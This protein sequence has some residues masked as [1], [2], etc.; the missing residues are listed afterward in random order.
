MTSLKKSVERKRLSVPKKHN[1][2]GHPEV[3][4][5]PHGMEPNDSFPVSILLGTGYKSS[6]MHGRGLSAFKMAANSESV[7][8]SIGKNTPDRQ[9]ETVGPTMVRKEAN[10]SNAQPDEAA[11][12]IRALMSNRAK[13]HQTTKLDS[14]CAIFLRGSDK[15]NRVS[16]RRQKATPNDDSKNPS[17]QRRPV[18]QRRN[19]T[20]TTIPSS[21]MAIENPNVNNAKQ[22]PAPKHHHPVIQAENS[23]VKT[24]KYTT[25]FSS[26]LSIENARFPTQVRT[27]SNKNIKSQQYSSCTLRNL[28]SRDNVENTPPKLQN[29]QLSTAVARETSSSEGVSEDHR[30]IVEF[31]VLRNNEGFSAQPSVC[32]TKRPKKTSNLDIAPR[33]SERNLKQMERLTVNWESNKLPFQKSHQDNVE[34]PAGLSSLHRN[35]NN[36][37]T[38]MSHVSNSKPSNDQKVST[39]SLR[40]S[41]RQV[42]RPEHFKVTWD[43]DKRGSSTVSP[44]NTNRTQQMAEC[45]GDDSTLLPNNQDQLNKSLVKNLDQS[46]FRKADN[47]IDSETG[48]ATEANDEF[49]QKTAPQFT[50]S[51]TAVDN[52]K[53]QCEMAPSHPVIKDN[54]ILSRNTSSRS[55]TRKQCHARNVSVISPRRSRRKIQP[56]DRFTVTWAKKTNMANVR[57]SSTT[58]LASR[59]SDKSFN[60]DDDNKSM[61]NS[62][63]GSIRIF[64]GGNT[65][66]ELISPQ[67]ITNQ[68]VEAKEMNDPRF[69]RN[70]INSPTSDIYLD[71]I[72]VLQECVSQQQQEGVTC[73]P[74]SYALRAKKQRNMDTI[75]AISPRRSKRKSLQTE[76]FSVTWTNQRAP[77]PKK[78]PDEFTI[79]A[80]E[81]QAD[82]CRPSVN[83]DE[84]VVLKNQETPKVGSDMTS[85]TSWTNNEV[86][87]LSRA[88]LGIDPTNSNFWEL[89]A[90]QIQNKDATEC[91]LRWFSIIQSCNKND[92]AKLNRTRIHGASAKNALGD[93][94]RTYGNDVDDIFNSTPYMNPL[95]CLPGRL[96]QQHVLPELEAFDSPII[97]SPM[98][99]VTENRNVARNSPTDSVPAFLSRSSPILE[100]KGYKGYIKLLSQ[101]SKVIGK[102]KKSASSRPVAGIG[103]LKKSTKPSNLPLRAFTE[104]GDIEMSATLNDCSLEVRG[105]TDLDLEELGIDPNV[106][107]DD[108]EYDINIA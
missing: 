97:H 24:A 92:Q 5:E 23:A 100:K 44:A 54:S 82:I 71:T 90:D 91:R 98:V 53:D 13:L 17:T 80:P 35:P 60:C 78:A 43:N 51:I 96:G 64:A 77:K 7:L 49:T 86:S 76:R 67:T 62:W 81:E 107:V 73:S 50:S 101:Q 55:S 95:F 63:D 74:P 18:A 2:T 66:S 108:C 88:V 89:V 47:G 85:T 12:K 14:M 99:R 56:T 69:D 94:A 84:T 21:L 37:L 106:S 26:L 27:T 28:G 33:R 1:S 8:M 29:T 19:A 61:C 68:R 10:T 105:P 70:S 72:K 20:I 103:T 22:I 65:A 16:H 79:N 36:T 30:N 48:R 15:P 32:G 52:C 83:F 4:T 46:L 59:P 11:Q 45:C 31:E 9:R 87:L 93:A 58:E 75:N 38:L 42:K 57:N 40:R 39:I 3:S 34:A 25:P 41:C 6:S 102:S 104:N